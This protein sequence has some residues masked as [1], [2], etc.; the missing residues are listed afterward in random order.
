MSEGSDASSR[1]RDGSLTNIFDDE[2]RGRD[3]AAEGLPFD[4]DEMA[5]FIEDDETQSERGAGSDSD[6]GDDARRRK[7]REKQKAKESRGR[8]KG[9]RRAGFG[10]GFVEG[11]T[12]EAWQEV[13]DVF[14]NGQDY[15]FA[16]D[17]E[18]DDEKEAKGLQDVREP[19]PGSNETS[20]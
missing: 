14:G 18:E 17:D 2:E 10:A 16:L 13:T 4:A 9:G 8:A 15:A 11:I 19:E 7:R 5:G 1:S 6:D 12:A 3:G 20:S